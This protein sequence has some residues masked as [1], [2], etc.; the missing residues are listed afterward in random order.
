MKFNPLIT[1]VLLFACIDA[2]ALPSAKN[3]LKTATGS[4]DGAAGVIDSAAQRLDPPGFAAFEPSAPGKGLDV[5][6]DPPGF[7]AFEPSAPGK[8]LDVPTDPPGAFAK[9]IDEVQ[10][11]ANSMHYIPM[12]DVYKEKMSQ[13]PFKD[14]HR[15][16]MNSHSYYS[17]KSKVKDLV[18]N[19]V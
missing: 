16:S 11:E 3:L 7:S 19:D 15:F 4:M 8:G 5:P 18:L 10:M 12:F 13:L 17:P 1:T 6:T 2:I 9:S 14:A